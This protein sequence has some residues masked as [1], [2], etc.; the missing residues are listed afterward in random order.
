MHPDLR[1]RVALV[2]LVEAKL[3]LLAL[4]KHKRV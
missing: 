4:V 3:T 1:I 2:Y